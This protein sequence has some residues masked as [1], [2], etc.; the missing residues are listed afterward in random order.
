MPAENP[1]GA[2]GFITK[3][4]EHI[5]GVNH[6]IQVLHRRSGHEEALRRAQTTDPIGPQGR[7]TRVGERI[8]GLNQG[9]QA[10]H[11]KHGQMDAFRRAK[12]KDPLGPN[13]ALTRAAEF[14]PGVNQGIQSFHRK[15][16]QTQA[17]ERAQRHDPLGAD[18]VLTRLG[19][20]IPVV[21]DGIMA[22]HVRAGKLDQADRVRARTVQGLLS[23]DG[24]VTKLAEVVPGL[25]VVAAALHELHGNDEEAHRAMNLL[26]NWKDLGDR[27]GA[28]ARLAEL[29]PGTDVIA[30]SAHLHDGSYAHAI[31]S[32]VKMPWMEVVVECAWVELTTQTLKELAIIR[33]DVEGVAINPK[34]ASTMGGLLDV[35]LHFLGVSKRQDG[36]RDNVQDTVRN[37]VNSFIQQFLASQLDFLNKSVLDALQRAD[38]WL[39]T[40]HWHL[41]DA[42]W[43]NPQQRLLRSLLGVAPDTVPKPRRELSMAMREAILGVTLAHGY[44]PTVD[45]VGPRSQDRGVPEGVGAVSCLSFLGCLGLHSSGLGCLGCLTGIAALAAQA[46]RMV[47]RRGLSWLGDHNHEARRSASGRGPPVLDPYEAGL[48]VVV[49]VDKDHMAFLFSAV[50]RYLFDQLLGECH[51]VRCLLLGAFRCLETLVSSHRAEGQGPS[52]PLAFDIVVPAGPVCSRQNGGPLDLSLPELH[53]LLFLDL[54]FDRDGPVVQRARLAVKDELLQ[55]LLESVSRQL[56]EQDMRTLHPCLAG[57]AEPFNLSFRVNLQWPSPSRPR[58]DIQNLYVKMFLPE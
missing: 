5:P 32:I 29:I 48:G 35:A 15:H 43:W 26:E 44:I 37:A 20:R 52:L 22:L 10:L 34:L 50:R 17:L 13:G 49:E 14:I 23:K 1:F 6:G 25:N 2:D 38:Y 58:L 8:P 12:T 28:L 18:G 16:G 21:N 39:H 31:R 33:L 56:M 19:E 30:F 55:E 42:T 51:W 46:G 24:A 7:L 4:G 9:I 11:H 57:F 53:L 41:Q 3:L 36:L 27:D 45:P 47:G 54:G 40:L